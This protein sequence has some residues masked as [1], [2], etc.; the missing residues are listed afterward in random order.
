MTRVCMGSGHWHQLVVT[1]FCCRITGTL[2]SVHSFPSVF[3]L[4]PVSSCFVVLMYLDN[5]TADVD[6]E[7]KCTV[8]F[9]YYLYIHISIILGFQSFI[10]WSVKTMNTAKYKHRLSHTIN[11]QLQCCMRTTAICLKANTLFLCIVLEPHFNSCLADIWRFL[12][13]WKYTFSF[14]FGEVRG[15]LVSGSTVE[16][17]CGFSWPLLASQCMFK[18]GYLLL[19]N[20]NHTA[21]GQ[22]VPSQRIL[23][24]RLWLCVCADVLL[25][26]PT[27]IP[28]CMVFI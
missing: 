17:C 14:D 6:A 20:D 12:H 7:Y 9:F 11:K 18:G 23:Y 21:Q 24:F 8:C 26:I 5:H 3:T 28:P 22:C 19:Y 25:K 1:Y 15:S 13:F 27:T 2:F 10:L 4:Y 16:L